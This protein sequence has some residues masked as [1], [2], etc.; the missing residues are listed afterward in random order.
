MSKL[1]ILSALCVG[2]AA[3]DA[4]ILAEPSAPPTEK[5]DESAAGSSKD[6][7]VISAQMASKFRREL[8]AEPPCHTASGQPLSQEEIDYR[9][10]VL[11]K[12][13]QSLGTNVKRGKYGKQLANNI[14]SIKSGVQDLNTG[15]SE[16]NE[17][18][19]D[20]KAILLHGPTDATI[21]SLPLEEQRAHYDKM[22]VAAISEMKKIKQQQA[23]E[24]TK[25]TLAKLQPSEIAALSQITET[26]LSAQEAK[27][28]G[29]AG[30][31]KQKEENRTADKKTKEE[32]RAADKKAKGEQRAA[33]KKAKDEKRAAE[34]KAKEEQRAAEKKAADEK[35]AEKKAAEK[36]AK[37][38]KRAARKEAKAGAKKRKRG[39]TDT[40]S[41]SD[42][43]SQK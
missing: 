38:E 32:Q 14:A 35:A 26:I 29:K 7:K 19:D 13:Q 41:E 27:S 16:A 31:A 28:K 12:R 3:L 4:S 9:K 11:E 20:L 33:E 34:K 6:V 30:A 42:T 43:N 25:A 18:L 10:K 22:R 23:D 1:L 8:L 2:A 24:K 40:D 15:V 39:S 21:S 5:P 17:K 37:D 36:K